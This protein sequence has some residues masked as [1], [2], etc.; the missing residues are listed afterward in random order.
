MRILLVAG[1]VVASL[2]SASHASTKPPAKI[3]RWNRAPKANETSPVDS[4]I[5]PKKTKKEASK[6][7]DEAVPVDVPKD[8]SKRRPFWA[9]KASEDSPSQEESLTNVH[10][11][12]EVESTHTSPPQPKKEPRKPFFRSIK[13]RNE[14]SPKVIKKEEEI[15]KKETNTTFATNDDENLLARN[16]TDNNSTKVEQAQRSAPAEKA[17]KQEPSLQTQPQ[18]TVMQSPFMMQPQQGMVIMSRSGPP[19]S[20]MQQPPSGIPSSTAIIMAS[21]A[22]VV[23]TALRIYFLSSLTRWFTDN[24]IKSLV[25]PKQHFMW[26]RLNDRYSKDEAA[27]GTALQAPPVG[28]GERTW[29]RKL[30]REASKE[31][32]I[33]KQQNRGMASPILM[34]R[35]VVVVDIKAG[36]AGELDLQ[37]LSEVVTFLLSQHR[38]RAFGSVNGTAKELEVVMVVESPGGA[39]THFG[40]AAAQVGRLRREEGITSTLIADEIIA[41]GGYMVACQADKLLA[42]P[43]AIVGSIGVI[44]E[45]YSIHKMLQ[46]Y[47]IEPVSLKAGEDKAPLTLLSQVTKKDITKTQEGLDKMHT[48]FKE[49]VVAGRPMLA[50][51]FED[52]CQGAIYLGSEAHSLKLIDGVMTSEEYILERIQAGDRVLK[53]HRIPSFAKTKGHLFRDLN[54]LDF[55]REH[56]VDVS[57]LMAKV[58][59]TTSVVQFLKHLLRHREG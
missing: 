10:I 37:H 47:G 22:G 43:F 40:L 44:R 14:D 28:V 19:G 30:E 12:F 4:K 42:A 38:Q 34:D 15:K 9:R 1:L 25:K 48:A 13:Q 36:N 11:D 58:L 35:T 27:L 2:L 18:L 3:S 31:R 50:D 5:G 23:S 54:P 51:H 49:L 24:E 33:L 32:K 53:L 41:S 6:T 57:Q 16:R 45:S 7:K 39:V 46:K 17:T 29:R 56:G 26:E 8:P 52:V 55:I 21:I 20:T 59:Q